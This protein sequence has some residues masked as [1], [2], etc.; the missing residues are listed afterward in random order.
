MAKLEAP[1]GKAP[2]I[3]VSDRGVASETSADHLQAVPIPDSLTA[4]SWAVT[5][6]EP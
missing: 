3:W 5:A 2:R 1:Y 6:C 4:R